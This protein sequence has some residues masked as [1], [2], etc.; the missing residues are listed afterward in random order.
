MSDIKKAKIRGYSKGM[1]YGA[2]AAKGRFNCVSLT[3]HNSTNTLFSGLWDGDC[4]AQYSA[5]EHQQ[6]HFLPC[7][8][9][10]TQTC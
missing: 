7:N 4:N 9:L 10:P 2:A 8:R 5:G 3:I 1:K 6:K